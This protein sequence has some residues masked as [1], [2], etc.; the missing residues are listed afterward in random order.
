MKLIQT[1]RE[2][3]DLVKTFNIRYGE[4]KEVCSQAPKLQNYVER[5]KDSQEYQELESEVKSE[6][7]RTLLDN[8]KLLQNALFSILL[9][10]RKPTRKIPYS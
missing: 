7:K 4:L 1:L 2:K 10:L 5:L 9:A 6:V 3:L 8:K